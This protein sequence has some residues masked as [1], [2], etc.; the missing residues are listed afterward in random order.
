[1]RVRSAQV[2]DIEAI[3]A[4]AR[5]WA[6]EGRTEQELSHTGFLVSDFDA[7]AYH[8]LLTASRFAYV[9]EHDGRVVGFLIGYA[10]DQAEMMGDYT[11]T[12]TAEKL[13]PFVVCKQIAVARPDANRGIGK[14]LYRHLIAQLEPGQDLIA[15][16]VDDPPNVRSQ[17]MHRDL[18]FVP[19]FQI[20]HPDGRS[21]TV[22]RYSRSGG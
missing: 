1:M 3:L 2:S 4:I 22:W 11:A 8:K 14:I 21:R 9:A 20:Q 18:G 12:K 6:V 5:S 15:A 10:G 19:V 13:G 7:A 17:R 16:V